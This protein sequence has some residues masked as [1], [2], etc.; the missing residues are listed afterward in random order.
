MREIELF[1]TK[2]E[3]PEG[4]VYKPEFVSCD[5]EHAL[6]NTIEQL[7]FARARKRNL[8]VQMVQKSSTRFAV[9]HMNTTGPRPRFDSKQSR[10]RT[11]GF[12]LT[13]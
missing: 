8:S 7:E 13:T 5:E 1:A 9:W 6:V 2:P 12:P 3:L 11:P 4:F 10:L